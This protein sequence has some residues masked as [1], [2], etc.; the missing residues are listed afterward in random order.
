MSADWHWYNKKHLKQKHLKQNQNEREEIKMKK[1]MKK[2]VA[3]MLVLALCA[4][5]GSSTE[6]GKKTVSVAQIVSHKSLNQIRDAFLAEM[7]ELGHTEENTTFN[8]SDAGGQQNVLN[9]I[10][11]EFAGANS[12]V[13]VA[14][15]TPTAMAA[16]NYA[17]D[18]PVIFSAV[19]DPVSAGLVSDINKPDK[20][21]TGTSDEI[22]VDKIL[23]LALKIQ[24][25][26]KTIGFLYNAGE[27]NSVSN[28]AKA[29]AFCDANNIELVEGS[30]KNISEIQSAISVL[31]AKCDAIFAPNDN[32]VA[33]CMAALVESAKEAKIPVYTGADSMV[34]DGG[35]ATVGIDYDEL[36]R[37]TA[38]MV[39]KVLNGEDIANI[40]VKVFKDDLNIYVNEQTMNDL[41]MTLPDSIANAENLVLMNE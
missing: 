2:L 23:E 5:C 15:A 22:Q 17:E 8:M 19:T 26:L 31:T 13:I 9:S 14:I 30:G 34:S 7:N 36:G 38:R 10:M 11:S 28:L 37:E 24:P 41:G 33:S 20:N 21:I 16:A 6:D 4:G 18:I 35:F 29:K 27:S 32:T 39:D 1:M 25:D 12:D 40:P 3:S